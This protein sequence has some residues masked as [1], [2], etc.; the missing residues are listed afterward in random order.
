MQ[1]AEPQRQEHAMNQWPTRSKLES[2]IEERLA[3]V[4]PLALHSG[5]VVEPQHVFKCGDRTRRVDF[6][7]SWRRRRVVVE[8]DGREF[9]EYREDRIRDIDLI[10]NADVTEIVRFQGG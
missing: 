10:L 9:H 7:I 6:L 2:P 1:L 8:C 5:C 3:A 4:L